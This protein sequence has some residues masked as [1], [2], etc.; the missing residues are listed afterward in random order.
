[1]E[2]FTWE[3]GLT[4]KVIN[5][6]APNQNR[7][8]FWLNL[9]ENNLV[10]N[11]T[12]IGGDL[13]FSLGMEESWGH[14]AQLYPISEQMST[15]L[16][17]YKLV[18]VPMSKKVPTWHNKRTGEAALGQRLDRFL[19]HEDL[20]HKLPLYRQWVGTGGLSDHLPIF[21]QVSGPTKKPR[22]TFKFFSGHLQDPDFIN[23]VTNFCRSQP[24]LR[25]QRMAADFCER[26]KALRIMTEDWS[27][28]KRLR[29][30]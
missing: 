22:S 21:L 29:D 1:M 30:N 14:H 16:D 23:L 6:Y 15:L 27:K 17:S 10:T 2:I 11:S 5:I 18:D 25:A 12:I 28:R 26:L 13:N 7:M 24:P 20:I 9:L 3:L 19:I 8:E 4:L